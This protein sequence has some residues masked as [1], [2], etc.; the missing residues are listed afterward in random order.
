MSV[1]QEP[2]GM[3]RLTPEKFEAMDGD[4][5]RNDDRQDGVDDLMPIMIRMEFLR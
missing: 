4:S 1:D 5:D 2:I 3:I